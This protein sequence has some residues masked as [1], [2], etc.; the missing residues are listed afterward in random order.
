MSLRKQLMVHD[1]TPGRVPGGFGNTAPDDQPSEGRSCVSGVATKT[2][3]AV[4]ALCAAVTA[5]ALLI[6]TSAPSAAASGAQAPSVTQQTRCG[7]PGEVYA[8]KVFVTRKDDRDGPL[9]S[10]TLFL[11]CKPD[12][13]VVIV[14]HEGHDYR[15]L[16]DFRANNEILSEDDE[17]TL[18]RDFPSVDR[19]GEPELKLM[20]VS[21]KTHSTPSWLWWLAGGS[22]LTVIIAGGGALWLR[23]HRRSAR[24]SASDAALQE[25]SPESS[26]G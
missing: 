26:S 5:L 14:D 23:A 19:P 2:G 10:I 17:I 7:S 21:G 11:V 20:T 16:G 13:V 18:P 15:D 1:G 6:P 4:H 22:L 8:Q 24:A 25:P 3:I 9:D 12:G